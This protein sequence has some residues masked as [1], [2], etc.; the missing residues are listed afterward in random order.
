MKKLFAVIMACGLIFGLSPDVHASFGMWQT[1]VI[2]DV[3]GGG[4]TFNE[5][6]KDVESF[7]ASFNGQSLGTVTSLVLKGAEVK[8]YKNSGS[9]VQGAGIF[10]NVRPVGDPVS[11]I[12]GDYFYVGLDF[13][14]NLSNPGDQTWYEDYNTFDL[15]AGLPPGDYAVDIWFETYGNDGGSTYNKD[16]NDFG[17]SCCGHIG[18]V[19]TATFTVACP[20]G[21]CPP[22]TYCNAGSCTPCP[23]GYYNPV[24]GALSCLPCEAG[25]YSSTTGATACLNCPAGTFQANTGSTSCS[26]CPAGTAQPN[27]GSAACIAC[28]SGTYQNNEGAATCNACEA[29]C[30]SGCD[31]VTGNCNSTAAVPT[32]GQWG[33]IIFGLLLLCSGAIVVWR[34]QYPLA[35]EKA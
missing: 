5:G 30:T 8:T 1:Y 6:Y 25:R 24:S 18:P 9:D 2:Y 33:L 13:G 22:G 3:N 12:H 29:A 20:T 7:A 35:G 14:V 17:Y 28:A 4:N 19:L 21:A 11:G 34:R 32:L 26:A 31:S 27:I 16:E 23:A 10:Y 15:L